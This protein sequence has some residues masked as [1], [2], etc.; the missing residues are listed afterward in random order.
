[1]QGLRA[2]A[3]GGTKKPHGRAMAALGFPL[4]DI[5]QSSETGVETPQAHT[6]G[7]FFRLPFAFPLI[8]RLCREVRVEPF[9]QHR[10]LL[11]E[12]AGRSARLHHVPSLSSLCAAPGFAAEDGQA[13]RRLSGKVNKRDAM[14]RR[15]RPPGLP[16][17]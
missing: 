3:L 14:L 10:I 1:M 6:F 4:A 13:R 17:S 11:P 15:A 7:A 9:G 2:R 12:I 8:I 5:R 16:K